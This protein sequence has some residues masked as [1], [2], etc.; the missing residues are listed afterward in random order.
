MAFQV[1]I[2]CH[3]EDLVVFTILVLMLHL[4]T[5]WF[6]DFKVRAPET[7]KPILFLLQGRHLSCCSL[8]PF[9]P[10]CKENQNTYTSYNSFITKREAYL[11]SL[12]K[13]EKRVSFAPSN[14][15]FIISIIFLVVGSLQCNTAS[16]SPRCISDRIR[17]QLNHSPSGQMC[18]DHPPYL[19]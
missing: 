18:S 10:V 2:Y 12:V 5:F 3:D 15:R 7:S 11:T 19:G 14:E 1:H 13:L 4:T 9:D 17:R 16:Y 6:L 8:L